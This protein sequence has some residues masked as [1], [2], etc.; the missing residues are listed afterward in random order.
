MINAEYRFTLPVSPK[1]AFNLLSDPARE[2][3]WQ[4][5]CVETK[6]LDGQ[7][8]AGCRYEITFQLIGRRMT[9][10]V[11]VL[12]YEPGVRSEF[13]VVE[14]PFGYLGSYEYAERQDG[15]ADVHWRFDVDPGNY[16]GIMPLSLV[17]KLLVSQVKKD[18]GKLAARLGAQ[19]EAS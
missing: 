8:S 7:A 13:K 4:S 15:T 11:E 17:K 10:T 9:F 5:A 1:E 6:L 2:P 19:R 18:S 16:F 3:E 14:G 12:A